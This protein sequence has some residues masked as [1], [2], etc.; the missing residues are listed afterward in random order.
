VHVGDTANGQSPAS[1]RVFGGDPAREIVASI[2]EL[3]PASDWAFAMFTAGGEIERFVSSNAGLDEAWWKRRAPLR[4]HAHA[5]YR[6]TPILH[7]LGPYGSGLTLTFA[8]RRTE[9]AA[10]TL[11]RTRELGPFA[12]SEIRLLVFALDWASERFSMLRLMESH[13]LHDAG[14]EYTRL[15][16]LKTARDDSSALYVLDQDYTIVLAWSAV[17]AETAAIAAAD[18]R[19]PRRIEECV[20]EL[21]RDWT[22]DAAT[23]ATGVAR[24]TSFLIVLTQPLAGPAGFFIGV[25]IQL[26]K[27]PHSLTAAAGRFAMSPREAQVLV[28]LLDGVQVSEIA[29]R[30]FIAPSTVQDHIKSLLHKT[31]AQ[32]RSQM[33]AKVLGWSSA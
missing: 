21:T 9:F 18:T 17:P 14:S 23:R 31:S 6:I 5:G 16:Q 25:V 20:R 26:F 8:D 24:P 13:E 19:L 7:G 29:E 33:I 3:V 10:L 15:D 30:L 27:E 12:S 1:K 2:V 11:L 22:S 4:S 28:L 32:N